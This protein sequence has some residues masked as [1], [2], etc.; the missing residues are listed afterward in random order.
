MGDDDYLDVGES[1]ANHGLP[2]PAFLRTPENGR[3]MGFWSGS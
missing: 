2:Y 3:S 1:G